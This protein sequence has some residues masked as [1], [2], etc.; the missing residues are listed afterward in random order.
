MT[1][2]LI[3]IYPGKCRNPKIIITVFTFTVYVTIFLAPSRYIDTL[4]N[5]S[6]PINSLPSATI[7]VAP[8]A[9]LRIDTNSLL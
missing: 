6:I 9:T 8:D 7:P 3:S 1:H 2:K 5:N 4:Q